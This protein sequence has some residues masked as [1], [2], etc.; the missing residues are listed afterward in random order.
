MECFQEQKHSW[1]EYFWSVVL[2]IALFQ[3][4]IRLRIVKVVISDATQTIYIFFNIV[5]LSYDYSELCWPVHTLT[6][7]ESLFLISLKKHYIWWTPCLDM[8]FYS[9][10]L[11]FY[12]HINIYFLI[13]YIYGILNP[14]FMK[15]VFI[16]L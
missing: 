4:S 9:W 7:P 8:R 10:P 1:I 6:G 14:R 2:S 15:D 3:T 11:T 16:W 13:P 12:R 5:F